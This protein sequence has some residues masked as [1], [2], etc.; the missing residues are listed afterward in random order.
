MSQW[1]TLVI[2]ILPLVYQKERPL[3]K[4]QLIAEFLGLQ[5]SKVGNRYRNLIELNS[6]FFFF[7]GI[8]LLT[9]GDQT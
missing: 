1:K 3:M 4:V 9:I 7:L 8:T 6:I 5:V 2:L